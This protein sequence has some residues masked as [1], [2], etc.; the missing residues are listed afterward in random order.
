[1]SSILNPVCFFL[2]TFSVYNV[3]MKIVEDKHV[4]DCGGLPIRL[5]AGLLLFY[6]CLVCLWDYQLVSRSDTREK[7]QTARDLNVDLF[8][9][10][11]RADMSVRNVTGGGNWISEKHWQL[12]VA[13]TRKYW[14][15]LVGFRLSDPHTVRLWSSLISRFVKC[16]CRGRATVLVL[17]GKFA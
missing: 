5:L 15:R 2:F 3:M 17:I 14:C 16:I 9:G 1:M 10:L 13:V 4:E 8:E 11:C 12:L 7:S 6:F